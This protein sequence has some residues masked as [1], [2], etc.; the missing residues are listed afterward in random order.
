MLINKK[1]CLSFNKLLV[2]LIGGTLVLC[3]TARHL[4]LRLMLSSMHTLHMQSTKQ[5]IFTC[6]TLYAYVQVI[7]SLL[8]RIMQLLQ[9]PFNR[10]GAGY[11][12]KSADS[13]CILLCL[14]HIVLAFNNTSFTHMHMSIHTNTHTRP[15]TLKNTT[16]SM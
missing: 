7:H 6:L 14:L 11:V 10:N 4:V 5:L 13:E 3:S 12:I 8:H 15:H 16:P 2:L 1:E 9:I